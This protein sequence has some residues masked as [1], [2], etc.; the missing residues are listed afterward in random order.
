[1][2]AL[3]YLLKAR[4]LAPASVPILVQ[5]GRVCL[6]RDLGQ[7]A[8]DALAIAY[9]ADSTNR[10]ALYLLA[11]A[12][13]TVEKYEESYRLLTEFARQESNN[14]T[15]YH[16]LGWLDLKLNRPDAARLHFERALQL[17]PSFPTALMELAELDLNAGQLDRSEQRV[18]KVL[19]Q[20]PESARAYVILG[21]ITSQRGDIESAQAR[22]QTAI[23]Y[24]PELAAAHSKLARILFRKRDVEGG[25]RE[26]KLAADLQERGKKQSRQALRLA[27]MDSSVP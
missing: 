12:H 5:F 11:A 22:Y 6:Q 24:E 21:D 23:R 26:Q 10:E 18:L 2:K 1:M 27:G 16:S 7:D 13:I 15:V 4:A 8:L 9:R 17:A 14:P 19:Q 25:S 20:K 3:A